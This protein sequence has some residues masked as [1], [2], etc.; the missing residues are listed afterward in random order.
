MVDN[1]Q[2]KR[3]FLDFLDQGE[4]MHTVESMLKQNR[5]RL[6][7]SLDD[8]RSFDAELTRSLMRRPAEYLPPFE[9]ALRE[10]V[11]Q[12]D[13][14]FAKTLAAHSAPHRSP[15][16]LWR[17]PRLTAWA[18][19]VAPQLAGV[20]RGNRDQVHDGAAE[21]AQVRRT[22]ARPPPS[23]PKRSTATSRRWAARQ[24]ARPTRPRIRMAICWRLSTACASTW[25]TR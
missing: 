4:Y 19:R 10:V 21:G 17:A 1:S 15:G 24:P 6:M 25:T 5:C 11:Q 9:E 13:P 18:G 7:L 3:A 8:L 12:Q 14:S 22:T 23:S 2:Q 16:L 20:R